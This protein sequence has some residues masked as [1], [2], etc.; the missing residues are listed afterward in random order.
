MMVVPLRLLAVGVAIGEYS[1]LGICSMG[2]E[3][4]AFIL[5]MLVRVVTINDVLLL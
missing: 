5:G 3:R 1:R 4:G 2:E